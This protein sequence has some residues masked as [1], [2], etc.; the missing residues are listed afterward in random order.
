MITTL[1]FDLARVLLFPTDKTYKGGLNALHKNLS[2]EQNYS[3]LSTFELNKELLNYLNTIKSIKELYI[4]TSGSIQNAQEIRGELDSIFRKI[5]S[6]EELG[7]SKKDPHVYTRIAESIGKNPEE[8]LFIDDS[9]ENI[10][11]AKKAKLKTLHF[12][13]AEE[14]MEYLNK[15]VLS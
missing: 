5:F 10:E 4:F 9:L 6:A 7:F 11:S 14:L 2:K 8:I 1:L 15:N 13:G 3:F 12:H